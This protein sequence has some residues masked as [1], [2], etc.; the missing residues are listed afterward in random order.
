M[1]STTP[2]IDELCSIMAEEFHGVAPSKKAVYMKLNY[3]GG[4]SN[5][6][7]SQVIGRAFS[8]GLVNFV[9]ASKGNRYIVFLTNEG[10]ARYHELRDTP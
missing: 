2:R 10:W 8:R 9:P 5:Y 4:S 1:E 6:Y 3:N 7:G